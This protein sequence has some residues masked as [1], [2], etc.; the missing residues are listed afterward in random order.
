MPLS[1]PALVSKSKSIYVELNDVAVD[2]LRVPGRS[3]FSVHYLW[4][5]ADKLTGII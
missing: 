1:L 2:N 3:V 4:I 5:S